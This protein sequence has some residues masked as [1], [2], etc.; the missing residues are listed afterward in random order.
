MQNYWLNHFLTG[1]SLS[2]SFFF[3]F[4]FFSDDLTFSDLDPLSGSADSVVDAGFSALGGLSGLGGLLD[5]DFLGVGSA[6]GG[7]GGFSGFS[8]LFSAVAGAFVLSG[9]ACWSL[10]AAA[11]VCSKG[12]HPGFFFLFLGNMSSFLTISLE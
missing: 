5:S 4:S 8:F 10:G 12:F 3:F 7:G 2:L 1:L 11:A 9:A 6:G